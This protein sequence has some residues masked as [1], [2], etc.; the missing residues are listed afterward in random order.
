M[1]TRSSFPENA[2]GAGYRSLTGDPWSWP[3]LEP[4]LDIT[5]IRSG[6]SVCPHGFSSMSSSTVPVRRPVRRTRTSS[7]E[8]PTGTSRSDTTISWAPNAL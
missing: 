4:T 5:N 6:S 8:R 2:N 1:S 3:T 7:L